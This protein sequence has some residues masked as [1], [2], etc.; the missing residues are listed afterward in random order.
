LIPVDVTVVESHGSGAGSDEYR[1][2]ESGEFPVKVGE[3]V[4][5]LPA[6]EV[7]VPEVAVGAA[8]GKTVAKAVPMAMLP[9][10]SVS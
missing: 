8:P 4:T 9:E 1:Q 10:V 3:K 6:A 5:V 2:Y 7:E